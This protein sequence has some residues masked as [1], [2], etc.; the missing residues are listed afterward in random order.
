VI[1]PPR[2]IETANGTKALAI[3]INGALSL[4]LQLD[5]P[6]NLKVEV[7]KI[8]INFTKSKTAQQRGS[9]WLR[10]QELEAQVETGEGRSKA[11]K[12]GAAPSA[13]PVEPA[14]FAHVLRPVN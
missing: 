11:D 7:K 12:H 8:E 2:S 5:A 9:L 4:S 3:L 13:L 1:S 10:R 14:Y 6:N